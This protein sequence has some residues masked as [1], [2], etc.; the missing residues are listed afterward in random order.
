MFTFNPVVRTLNVSVNGAFIFG[1]SSGGA[2][3]SIQL[4]NGT[5][6]SIES[7]TLS[8]AVSG[9]M[10]ASISSNA[11]VFGG[12]NG[13][14]VYSSI[15]RYDGTTRSTDASTLSTPVAYAGCVFLGSSIFIFGGSNN[16]S[17]DYSLIQRYSG[18]SLTVDS[19]SL[20]TVKS[21]A[22]CSK[23]SSNAFLFGGFSYSNLA[24]NTILRY[25]GTSVSTDA[26]VTAPNGYN[27]GTYKQTA[28][29]IGSS[30]FIFG[31]SYSGTAINS[32]YKYDGTT[33]SAQAAT[34]PQVDQDIS[35]AT[36][37]SEIFVFLSTTGYKFSGT[38]GTSTS[39]GLT[40][41]NTGTSAAAL[42]FSRPYTV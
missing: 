37:Q 28:S 15:Q 16:S 23:I 8:S 33:Y 34:L 13:T 31:G 25:D 10:A 22:A 12:A 26:A 29:N 5:E 39:T 3:N 19:A 24:S 2:G 38:T 30:I 35:S 11:F 21:N 20:P 4:F 9:S 6:F 1:A 41:N 40:L 36:V 32:I 27:S 7:A 18:S 42:T 14:S 17:T